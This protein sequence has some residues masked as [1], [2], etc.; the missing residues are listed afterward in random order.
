MFALSE[1]RALRGFAESAQL[2]PE[3]VMDVDSP[4]H[5]LN[6]DIAIR[7]LLSSGNAARAIEQT[8]EGAVRQA[9]LIMGLL[10]DTCAGSGSGKSQN[11]TAF[12]SRFLLSTSQSVV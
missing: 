3:E 5:Y 6:Y 12:R 10:N 1:E 4:V 7:G 2:E 11:S 9:Y 8:S